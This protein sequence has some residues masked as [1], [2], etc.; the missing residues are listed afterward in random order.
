MKLIKKAQPVKINLNEI[1]KLDKRSSSTK[2]ITTVVE[3][4]KQLSLHTSL[5][6][7]IALQL[8]LPVRAATPIALTRSG[9]MDFWELG[10]VLAQ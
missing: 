10:L 9:K 8:T 2:A 1:S 6:K 3:V 7:S 4:M 5:R